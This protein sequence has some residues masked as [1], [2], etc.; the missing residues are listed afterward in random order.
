M[1]KIFAGTGIGAVIA[2]FYLFSQAGAGE[3]KR[4]A[5]ADWVGCSSK[6]HYQELIDIAFGDDE[7]A[8]AEMVTSGKC[9]ALKDGAPVTVI[10]ETSSDVG[11]IA[12][13]GEGSRTAVWTASDAIR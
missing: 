2:A 12:I 7:D 4:I 5:G 1:K 8:F 6:E 13:R 9:F 11:I 10:D 3:I